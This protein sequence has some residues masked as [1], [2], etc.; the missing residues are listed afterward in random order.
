MSTQVHFTNKNVKTKSEKWETSFFLKDQKSIIGN[1]FW[2]P[3]SS[4]RTLLQPESS[5]NR[6]FF[7]K[8]WIIRPREIPQQHKLS[9]Q[10][11]GGHVAWKQHLL[12]L[13]PKIVD[14]IKTWKKSV[15]QMKIDLWG[16]RQAE[17]SAE[18]SARAP[19]IN[20]LPICNIT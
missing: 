9:Q 5:K 13:L 12:F 7:T 6:S 16:G 4:M 17:I 15:P 14:F 1:K 19:P 8:K 18:I 10:H 3:K 2:P 11:F 20:M